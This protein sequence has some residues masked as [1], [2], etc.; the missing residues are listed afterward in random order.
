MIFSPGT[1]AFCVETREPGSK[2]VLQGNNIQNELV[3]AEIFLGRERRMWRRVSLGVWSSTVASYCD[4]HHLQ[5]PLWVS[6]DRTEL[7]S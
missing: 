1:V 5:V 4:F 3:Q 7:P 6:V 2:T